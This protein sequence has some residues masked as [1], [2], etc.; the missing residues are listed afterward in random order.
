MPDFSL[1]DPLGNALQAAYFEKRKGLDI[2][3]HS[4]IAE[5]DVIPVDWMFRALSEMPKMEVAMLNACRGKVLDVGAGAG[6]HALA[7]Q[8]KGLKVHALDN[9]SGAVKVMRA[10]GVVHVLEENLWNYSDQ[11]Y[12]TI[13]LVMNGIGLAGALSQVDAFFDHLLSLLAPDGQI[14]LDSSDIAYFYPDVVVAIDGPDYYGH[15]QY[16]MEFEGAL[17]EW[18]P[19]LYVDLKLLKKYAKQHGLKCKPIAKDDDDSFAVQLTRT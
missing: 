17:T 7:L 11:E 3:V 14:L 19:W 5:V 8:Q 12:D 6:C 9:S 18:F 1:T 16:Q 15:V 4:D 2:Q 10:Q 13:L